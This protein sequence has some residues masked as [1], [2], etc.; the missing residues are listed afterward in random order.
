MQKK[1]DFLH[2]SHEKETA[3]A[4][5]KAEAAV[6]PTAFKDLSLSSLR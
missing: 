2:V 1:L 6:S 5:A 4:A 3:A